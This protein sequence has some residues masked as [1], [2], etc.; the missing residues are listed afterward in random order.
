MSFAGN[1]TLDPLSKKILPM[2][3]QLHGLLTFLLL[4]QLISA[5]MC[6]AS[7]TPTAGVAKIFSRTPT[8]RPGIDVPLPTELP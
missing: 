2:I 6:F 8:L 1:R 3:S 4:A 7:H 5:H